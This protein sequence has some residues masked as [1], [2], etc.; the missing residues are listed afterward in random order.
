MSGHEPQARR[1]EVVVVGTSA[2][3]V[4]ALE[5]FLGRMPVDFPIP[6]VIVQHLAPKEISHLATILRARTKLVVVEAEDKDP[7]IPGT[8]YVAPPNY[9]VLVESN[10]LLSLDADEPVNF[11]RPSADLL[12]FSAAAS[13]GKSVAA[14]VLTGANGDGA[15]GA[16]TI[17]RAGGMVF[18]QTPATAAF[19]V[20][21]RLTLERCQPDLVA[22]VEDLADALVRLAY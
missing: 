10:R 4:E 16:A 14:V 20:M 1:F 11:C 8:V 21:P 17:R 22:P 3:G 15:E 7:L 2:G 19:P 9:H 18:V 5:R 6:I 12:F 13:F